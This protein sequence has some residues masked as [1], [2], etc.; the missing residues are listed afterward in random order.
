[1][2]KVIFQDLSKNLD[3][4]LFILKGSSEVSSQSFIIAEILEIGIE[5]IW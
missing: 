2:R 4:G 5:L 3:L 1:M